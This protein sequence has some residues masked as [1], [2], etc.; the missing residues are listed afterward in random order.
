MGIKES[1]SELRQKFDADLSEVRDSESIEK[2]RVSYLGKKGSVTELLKGLKDLSG[3]EKK[4]FGQTINTLKREVDERITAHVELDTSQIHAETDI[5][6]LLR[7][8]YSSVIM[9]D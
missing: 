9:K 5:R 7:V 8:S 4:E 1:I 2:L 3:A 6:N